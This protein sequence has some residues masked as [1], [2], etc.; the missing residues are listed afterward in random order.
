MSA[1]V[2]QGECQVVPLLGTVVNDAAER[3]AFGA[4]L[5]GF[6]LRWGFFAKVAD[7]ALVL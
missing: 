5:K 7:I 3:V 4:S 1:G 2:T 6:T